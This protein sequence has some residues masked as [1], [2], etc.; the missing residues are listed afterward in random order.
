MAAVEKAIE[1]SGATKDKII[2]GNFT[3]LVLGIIAPTARRLMCDV[4]PCGGGRCF[5]TV[6]AKGDFIPCGEFIGFEQFHAGN[7]FRSTIK[8]AMD[9]H[10]FRKVRARVVERIG[11]CETCIF[12][13]ICGAPCPAELYSTYEDMYKPSPYCDFYKEL[14][15]YAFKVIA[16]D[17]VKH[18]FRDKALDKLE[19]KYKYVK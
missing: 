18:L 5:L 17:K 11:E 3:N 13:N 4:T 6:T 15:I 9:S 10:A 12:R 7:I 2:I 8:E 16:E 14:T 1:L 19:Y